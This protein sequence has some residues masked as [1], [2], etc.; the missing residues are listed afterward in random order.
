MVGNLVQAIRKLFE[1]RVNSSVLVSTFWILPAII[2]DNVV[3][4][5]IA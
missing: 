4:T 5:Q 3:V 1:R 2:Q